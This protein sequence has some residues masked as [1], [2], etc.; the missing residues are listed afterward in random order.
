MRADARART[1][2]N[3]AGR[4]RG[5]IVPLRTYDKLTEDLHDLVVVAERRDEATRSLAEVKRRLASDG[6]I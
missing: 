4:R 5:M 1:I 2:V 3:G 6:A